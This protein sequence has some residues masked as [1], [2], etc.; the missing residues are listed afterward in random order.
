[1]TGFDPLPDVSITLQRTLWGLATVRPGD[2][3]TAQDI[4]MMLRGGAQSLTVAQINDLTPANVW[5][6]ALHGHV[7]AGDSISARSLSY[8]YGGGELT[9]AQASRFLKDGP[10]GVKNISGGRFSLDNGM[11]I[12]AAMPK[13]LVL[14]VSL[15]GAGGQVI[16]I[17]ENSI[18]KDGS[19]LFLPP[20]LGRGGLP[21][22][23]QDG[24]GLLNQDGSGLV[25]HDGGS[26]IGHDGNSLVSH[27]GVSLIG[28]GGSTLIGQ[29][30][31]T[32]IGQGSNT[33]IGQGSNT[34]R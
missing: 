24:S 6:L 19:I 3:V 34:M 16:I 14:S 26:L 13:Q 18:P 29:G 20:A 4:Q 22:L 31:N 27:D 7:A 32:L 25:S 15:G 30:S 11:F 21:L 33:L 12:T 2:E 5:N 1:M 23:H 9:A 10:T 28:H 17:P 8:A